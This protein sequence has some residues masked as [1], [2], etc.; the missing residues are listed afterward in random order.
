MSPEN[1]VQ[2]ALTQA[3]GSGQLSPEHAAQAQYYL[4][5]LDQP[6]RVGILGKKGM[7]K[8]TILNLLIGQH[9]LP[10]E[11]DIPAIKLSFA[12]TSQMICTLPDGS[13]TVLPG[14]DLMQIADLAPVYVELCLPLPALA[15]ISLLEVVTPDDAA[16]Q[17]RAS[18]WAA[19]RSD[20][21]LLCTQSFDA[22]EN[23]IWTQMPDLIKNHAFLVVTKADELRGARLLD[24]AMAQADVM[25]RDS[26]CA[27]MAVAAKDAVAA[28]RADG[29]VDKDR[30][31]VSG[32]TALISAVRKQ[33]SFGKQAVV[34]LADILLAQQAK[35][36]QD[37]RSPT[38]ARDLQANYEQAVARIIALGNVLTA[39]PDTA[40]PNEIIA[41]I[42]D[43][44]QWLC[45]NLDGGVADKRP[46]TDQMRAMA[47][48]A[49]DLVQLMQME[50]RGNA[51][52]DAVSLLL[53]VKHE[54]QAQ[55]AA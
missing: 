44:L 53:Q 6:L 19:K 16:A 51:A 3:I 39:L 40:G 13:K 30:M 52:Q 9:I 23:A 21:I 12:E 37:A 15:K 50:K 14:G 25:G 4:D 20:V 29:T 17:H 7:G 32:G 43:E 2:S 1:R 54:L 46:E 5:R 35:P 55:L 22:G 10:P 26:F 33:I 45:A 8:S 31:R 41:Q 36:L 18:Q 49:A 47:F 38:G 48:D 27:V 42:A 24:A 11:L 28:R 34:D